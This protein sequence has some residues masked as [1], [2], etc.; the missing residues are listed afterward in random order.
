MRNFLITSFQRRRKDKIFL[1]YQ[2][3][4]ILLLLITFMVIGCQKETKPAKEIDEIILS[5][6]LIIVSQNPIESFLAN[7]GGDELVFNRASNAPILPV[8]SHFQSFHF[9]DSRKD[10]PSIL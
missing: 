2:Q 1:G 4:F 9:N 10:V 8:S 7:V 6:N 5:E 3:L